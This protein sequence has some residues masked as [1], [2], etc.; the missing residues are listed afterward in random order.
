MKVVRPRS[1]PR[2]RALP[3]LGDT[4]LGPIARTLTPLL[5]MLLLLLLLLL[6]RDSWRIPIQVYH[7]RNQ[8]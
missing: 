6:R 5:S 1:I 7:R 3:T 8:T 4:L 2:Q